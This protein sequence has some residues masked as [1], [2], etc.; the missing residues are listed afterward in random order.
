MSN[1][2][3]LKLTAT[4]PR[5]PITPLAR[6][7]IKLLRKLEQQ[8]EAA[9]TEA[10]DEEFLEEIKRWVRNEETGEK[11]LVIQHKPVR[12]WW[13]QNQHGAWMISL[14]DGNRLIP[15]TDDNS[16]VEVGAMEQMASSL[17]TLRDAG[18]AGE[19]NG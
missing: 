3:K 7:R 11:S 14:R 9:E 6:K 12:R 8:I 2:A 19:L 17:K 4:S 1:L 18:I 10:G 16:S 15:L 13:W 5:E